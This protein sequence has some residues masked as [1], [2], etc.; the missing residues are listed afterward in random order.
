MLW[1]GIF[2]ISLLLLF[3][4]QQCSTE[5]RILWLKPKVFSLWPLLPKLY[6]KYSHLWLALVLDQKTNKFQSL[7]FGFRGMWKCSSGHSLVHN[8]IK[9]SGAFRL[10]IFS[11]FL[12][13]FMLY[14]VLWYT[15]PNN[16]YHFWADLPF[17]VPAFAYKNYI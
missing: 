10:Y 6:S 14:T 3:S 9:P 7:T 15:V 4:T 12:L 8:D 5:G 16:S 17:F 11:P 13:R 1:S 2:W